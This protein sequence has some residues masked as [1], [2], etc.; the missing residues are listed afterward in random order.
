MN[1][2][3]VNNVTQLV[4]QGLS[5][6]T[7]LKNINLTIRSGEF[8]WL[9]GINGAGKTTLL[10]LISGLTTPSVGEVKLMGLEPKDA[11]AKLHV[12]I[13]FQATQVP[14]NMKVKELI[15]LFKTYSPDPLSFA[16]EEILKRVNLTKTGIINADTVSLSG[17]EKQRLYLALA[18]VGNPKLLILDEP[19]VNLDPDSTKVFWEQIKL[20][21]E[22]GVTILMTTQQE[23]D[24][25]ELN[26]LATRI[27]TVHE[28]AKAP[29]DGQLTEEL[30]TVTAE[31]E[32]DSSTTLSEEV[33]TNIPSRNLL[34]VFW[35]Q[36]W[37]ECLQLLRTPTFLV[38][39]LSFV[40]FV[41]LLK[42][43]HQGQ[44]ALAPLIYLSAIILFTI[45]IERLG[46]RVAIERSEGWIKLLKTTSLPPEIYMAAK[47]SS[48]L[49]VCAVGVLSI[50]TL[51]AWQLGV[52]ASLGL[53]VAIFLSLIIGI[54]PFAILGL[55]LGYWLHP[56]SAD[57]ILSLSLFI[58]PFAAGAIPLPFKPEL[59][60]DL[61]SLSPVYHYKELV[62]QA[63]QLPSDGQIFLHLLW[64]VWAV[65]VF[66]ISAIWVY[67]RDRSIQ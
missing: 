45:T 5:Q 63:A 54:I 20:C 57:S 3:E 19:T 58:L 29:V 66:G 28:I 60:Q 59:M 47:I 42:S 56:K 65:G 67:Q 30:S 10:S 27:V 6:K 23:S 31:I 4:R 37:F 1:V 13:I 24:W 7:I 12:G 49:I 61:V 21:R 26:K 33:F 64:L 62:L 11:N 38:A 9:K 15:E 39:T 18:L 44:D 50:F 35:K 43:Q 25:E 34:D 51:G 36:L 40:G 2:I 16:T 52:Q 8:V 17:G 55:E 41:P 53:W 46:K 14:K 22:R 32:S 48:F